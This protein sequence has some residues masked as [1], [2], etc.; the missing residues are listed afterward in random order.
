MK[1][2]YKEKENIIDKKDFGAELKWF[3]IPYGSNE[4]GTINT[5]LKTIS[6]ENVK[7]DFIRR[8]CQQKLLWLYKPLT[9]VVK[10]QQKLFFHTI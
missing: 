4:G 8:N 1:L 5:T 2:T 6:P 10:N 3:S 9:W 7:A